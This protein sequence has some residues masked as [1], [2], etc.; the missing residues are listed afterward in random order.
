MFIRDYLKYLLLERNYS[1]LTLAVYEESLR[2]FV[3]YVEVQNPSFDWATVSTDDVRQWIVYQMDHGSAPATVNKR[4]SALRSFY[5][6]LL[7]QEAVEVDPMRKIKGPKAPKPLPYFFKESEM[8]RLLDDIDFGIGFAPLRDKLMIRMF[9]TTGVRLAELVGLD[10]K[11]VDFS[12]QQLK[13]TGKRNKQ[14][15]IP[16]GTE[17]SEALKTYLAQKRETYPSAGGAL[18]LAVSGKRISPSV[19]SHVVRTRL[20][21]VTTL[22]KKSPHVLRHTFATTMLNHHADLEVVKEL[23]G[24]DSLATTEVYT[25]TTF[26]ELKKEYKYAHPRA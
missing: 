11:D 6:Y 13:V 4:L 8:D 10:V 17:L 15:L 5:R 14:R 23:L 12:A 19:V 26:E 18:F 2:S 24:H 1:P 9:Y 21:Q 3:S 7:I 20:S 25:H 22:K 16:F